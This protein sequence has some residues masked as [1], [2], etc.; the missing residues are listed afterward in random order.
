MKSIK[1]V[2]AVIIQDGKVLCVQRPK[3]TKEYISLKWE[4]PGGKVEVGE[5]REE[6]LV[7]EIQEELAAEIHELQFLMTVEHSYPDFHLT[8]HAYSCT[9]KTG[10]ISLR[11][12]V[13]MKWLATEELN[14][15]DWAEADVPVVKQLS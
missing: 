8:M 13:D 9:L 4:F 1:V 7:R 5:N 11:E 3:H 2:A 15:L 14:Q 6:A 12:H 10:E